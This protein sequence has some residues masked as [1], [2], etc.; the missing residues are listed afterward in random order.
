[1]KI[2]NLKNTNYGISYILWVMLAPYIMAV[3]KKL[4]IFRL[5]ILL[6]MKMDKLN[7]H[8]KIHGQARRQITKGLFMKNNQNIYLLKNLKTFILEG[9][10]PKMI[11][12]GQ[13]HFQLV[14]LH[15]MP[16]C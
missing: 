5:I 3:D 7:S 12:K 13:S 1:M 6:W 11:F 16:P 14:L 15:L 4:E 9:T 8:L 2:G 10:L